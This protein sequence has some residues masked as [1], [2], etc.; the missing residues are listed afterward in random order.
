MTDLLALRKAIK[1]KKPDFV[2]QDSHKK[3]R[4]GDAW[5]K[6]KGLHS[7]MRHKSAGHMSVVSVGWGSPAEV[8]GL[9][10]SGLLP[11]LV[12]GLGDVARMDAKKE[13][14][15]IGAG[16]GD[17][18]KIAL[19][20]ALL[21]KNVTIL[22]LKDAKGFAARIADGLKKRK[23]SKLNVQTKKE[24]HKE[25]KP[26]VKEAPKEMTPEEKKEHER[27]EAEKVLTHKER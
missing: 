10:P 9:H 14:A 20:D 26:A 23:E 19:V 27:R 4:L 7:K 18:R 6:P 17:R 12:H 11:V 3:V 5:R 1:S 24:S 13:G 22:N 21:K 25:T 8:S 16:V 2:R 15:I